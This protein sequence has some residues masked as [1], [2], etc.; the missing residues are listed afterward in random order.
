MDSTKATSTSSMRFSLF[1]CFCVLGLVLKSANSFSKDA[2]S[3]LPV[4]NP[5]TELT[6]AL[7]SHKTMGYVEEGDANDR[8]IIFIHGSPSDHLTWTEP[9]FCNAFP[10]GHKIA[11]DR[12]GYGLSEPNEAVTELETHAESLLAFLNQNSRQRPI[13]VGHSYGTPIAVKLALLYPDRV[14]PLLL[15]GT[16]IEPEAS[17]SDH[18]F[19]FFMHFLTPF[20]SQAWRNSRDEILHLEH[21]NKLMEEHLGEI[22]QPVWILHGADDILAPFHNALYA[23][24]KMIR[25]DVHVIR[26]ANTS[27]NVHNDQ[28]FF[29][30]KLLADIYEHQK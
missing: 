7:P 14:G 9:F 4:C 25:A 15:M 11:V 10:Q 3:T 28:P 13:V 22:T 5:R 21:E 23:R 29:V 30:R 2:L 26:L 16:S 6:T 24:D 17:M 12:L 20:A 27:H 1:E 19:T 18:V 8:T